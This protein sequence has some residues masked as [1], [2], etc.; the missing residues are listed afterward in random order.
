MTHDLDQLSDVLVVGLAVTGRAVTVYVIVALP[1]WP[2]AVVAVTV[3]V[4]VPTTVV[5]ST[6]EPPVLVPSEHDVIA[7]PA[8]AHVN[9]AEAL[10]SCVKLVFAP[11][12][13]IVATGPGE[14]VTRPGDA[15]VM[16]PERVD[17]AMDVP[18]AE[19]TT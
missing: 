8:D 19:A 17:V 6:P 10:A 14:M 3:Y 16:V 4:C 5:S 18:V 13:V 11:G 7:S 15:A 1:V 12:L 2:S 9:V